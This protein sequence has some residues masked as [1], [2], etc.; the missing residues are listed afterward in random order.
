MEREGHENFAQFGDAFLK[1]T[2]G[3]MIEAFQIRARDAARAAGVGFV[4]FGGLRPI[5]VNGGDVKPKRRMSNEFEGC[6]FGERFCEGER[7]AQ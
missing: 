7:P 1:R 3:E 2:D 5:N 6:E 4:T